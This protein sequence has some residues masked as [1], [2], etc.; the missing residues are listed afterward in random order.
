MYSYSNSITHKSLNL[1]LISSASFI[2][3]FSFKLAGNFSTKS[4]D[5]F[6]PKFKNDLIS[7]IKTNFFAASKDVNFTLTCVFF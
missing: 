6:N 5:S 1:F 2:A 4:L 3:T 7:F